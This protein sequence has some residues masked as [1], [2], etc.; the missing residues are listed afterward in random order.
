MTRTVASI[1]P[2]CGVG[3]GVV[4]EARRGRITSVRGD[5]AH[6]TNRG[7]LCSKGQR[8]AEVV[9]TRDRLLFP[10]IGGRRVAWDEAI[11]HV[12]D[13]LRR[14]VEAG[15]PG[16]V[17]FYLS[18]QLLTEDYYVA[19]KLA[20]GLLGTANVDTNSRLC[21]ASTVAAYKRAF[22]ADGPPGCYEDLDEATHVFFWGSNAAETHP[23][24]FGRLEAARR[25]APRT[26]VAID[27]R[28]TPTAAA[29]DLHLPLRPGSDVALALAMAATLFQEGLV[30]EAAVRQRCTGLDEVREA[31]LTLP[32]ELAAPVCGVD[33]ER[34]R[35]VAR[36]FAGAPAALS[37]WCQGL[38]QSSAGTDKVNAVINLHLLTGQIARPGC[39]PFSLTGQS[40]AMGGREVGGMATE[41][42]AHHRL[43][44][45]DDRERVERFWGLGPVPSRRGLTAVE[46]IEAI[47]AGEVRVLWVVCTNPLASLP[48]GWAA[49]RA[50]ESLDLLV[51]QE[52]YHPTDTSELADVLLPAAGWAEKTGTMTSSER[53]VA[54]AE[55]A[56]EPPGEA[57]PDWEIFAAVG[58]ALGGGSAFAWPD[59]A[60]VFAEH[61]ALTKGRDLDMSGLSH[62]LLRQRGPQQWPYPADGVPTA[63]R[64]VDGV[65]ATADGRA[66]LVPV[67]FRPPAEVPDR[68][69]PLRLTTGRQRHQWHTMTRTGRVAAL[70]QET[71]ETVISLSPRDAA[72]ASLD[73]GAWVV[74]ASP[75]GELRARVRIDP[76][77]PEGT[78]FLPF[79]R[80]P[81]R[82]PTGWT[83]AL[84]GRALDPVSFQPELKH[85]VVRVT[86]APEHISLSGEALAAEVAKRLR[87][88]GIDA[89]YSGDP[90]RPPTPPGRAVFI[91][92]TM[93]EGLPWWEPPG[94]P[95]DDRSAGP[96]AGEAAI[97]L[98]SG[99]E[100]LAALPRL[101]A[102][103]WTPRRRGRLQ[104]PEAVLALL[105]PLLPEASASP[106][107]LVAPLR[108]TA[109]PPLP[110]E[111]LVLVPGGMLAGERPVSG[112]PA[113]LADFLAGDTSARGALRRLVVPL[114]DGRVL[115][116]LG[117]TTRSTL[118]DEFVYQDT[119]VGEAQVW[120]LGG[121][122]VLGVAAIVKRHLVEEIL[123]IWTSDL[124]PALL[125]RRLPLR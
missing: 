43:E 65:Y 6:P 4:V 30:D 73:E 25:R 63:R 101:V 88:R 78:A 99:P 82:E 91:A 20:K 72:E 115:V 68:G 23:I 123:E 39:G 19:N 118:T 12:A 120:H 57:R 106:E 107:L 34:I 22:G 105:D 29:S 74:V 67:R 70:R 117:D 111:T 31:A 18:G 121:G 47:A 52:L 114:E 84:L 93:G 87:S 40:N 50:L 28:R 75:R 96:G 62:D 44:D 48:D 37:L 108:P 35:A 104:L 113:V 64:Y 53:R 85:T 10:M 100:P 51:V 61:V 42:A 1:C 86:R 83:N 102:A 17:A 116:V 13:G 119:S 46:L 33:A 90:G 79:H 3:C 69:Y 55:A 38:N 54:L 45:P 92:G 27:P 95:S 124:D 24:L 14:A 89:T 9:R 97:D 11:A 81:L 2:Y 77:Q 112:D 71:T 41:L 122:E 58:R 16:A 59:A 32:P 8:L 110:R 98:S 15:G 66:R 76:G 26:W 125:R 60:A 7:G 49:R 109:L 21:M 103:G 5:P 80:G 36:D 94:A 56:L